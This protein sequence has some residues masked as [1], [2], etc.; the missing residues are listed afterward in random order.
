MDDADLIKDFRKGRTEAF[1]ELVQKYS[2]PLTM[3][4]FRMIRDVEESKDISQTVFLK[5]YEGLPGFTMASSFKT[6]LYKIALN[7]VRDYLRKRKPIH[8]TDALETLVDPAEPT[9]DSLDKKR[10]LSR[11]REAMETLPPKQR[12]TLQ[13]RV[14][15]D[16][17]YEEIAR[18]LGG[19]AGGARVNFFQAAKALRE[20][21][22]AMQ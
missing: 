17:D 14:Y 8:S 22:G 9:W 6:W 4:I 16:M 10:N 18:V 3:T 19:T 13:L 11:M 5:A 20:K 21:L 1:S 7:T 2:K 12:L 15:E